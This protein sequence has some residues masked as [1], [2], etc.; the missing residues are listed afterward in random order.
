MALEHLREAAD[1]C[2]DFGKLGHGADM[3]DVRQAR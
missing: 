1:G 2:F 3:A